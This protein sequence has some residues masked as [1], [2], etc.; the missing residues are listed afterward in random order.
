MM[1]RAVFRRGVIWLRLLL[2]L[3]VVSSAG[4]GTA[5]WAQ[6]YIGA[7]R[8]GACHPF[9]Y[10]RWKAG[11]HARAHLSL[12][13][14]QRRD[15]KCNTCHPVG[16]GAGEARSP[17]VQCERCHGAGRYYHPRYVMKDRELSRAVGLIDPTEAHCRTCHDEGAPTIEPFDFERAWMRIDHGA[18][19]RRRSE[20]ARG[21][22][23]RG[24]SPPPKR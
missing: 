14:A 11:P 4:F 10:A 5:L 22:T 18:E 6:E 13:E 8:C 3:S 17:G 20:E 23:N 9:A 2:A 24:S 1:P 16:D 7:E 19:A 12:D 15:P 21:T